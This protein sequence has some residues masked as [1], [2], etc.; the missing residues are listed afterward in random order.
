[1]GIRV[2]EIKDI[3]SENPAAWSELVSL[4]IWCLF[5]IIFVEHSPGTGRRTGGEWSVQ[6]HMVT[7]L[8]STLKFHHRKS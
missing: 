6:E 4:T 3:S 2:R 7:Q 1:M 8:T 5:G